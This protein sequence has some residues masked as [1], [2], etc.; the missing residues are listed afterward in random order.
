MMRNNMLTVLKLIRELVN[1]MNKK[2]VLDEFKTFAQLNSTCN[3]DDVCIHLLDQ[4]MQIENKKNSL[5]VHL[6][7][8]KP[9]S[10]NIILGE[11][12]QSFEKSIFSNSPSV[13]V[14]NSF[15]NAHHLRKFS[16]N[17]E[18]YD[19]IPDKLC[20]NFN[21]LIIDIYVIPIPT[22][23]LNKIRNEMKESGLIDKFICFQKDILLDLFQ[24]ITPKKIQFICRYK[25]LIKDSYKLFDYIT[26]ENNKKIPMLFEKEPISGNWGLLDINKLE[27]IL[28]N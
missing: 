23:I 8:N 6:L 14:K 16:P 25:S 13:N 17:H 15:L 26:L 10:L 7:K 21:T 1:I 3:E 28:K 11:I 24:I 4:W 2:N 9:K 27:K 12:A 19:S 22:F 20:K 18:N 5:I